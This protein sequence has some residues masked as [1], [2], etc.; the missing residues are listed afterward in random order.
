MRMFQSSGLH[1]GEPGRIG[2]RGAQL[3]RTC[4]GGG[5]YDGI[6]AQAHVV[7]GPRKNVKFFSRTRDEITASFPE[8]PDS[9][10]G[11]A[12]D[13]ILDGEILA[14]SYGEGRKRGAG[15]S[16]QQRCSSGSDGKKVS[17]ELMRRVPVV[18]IVC[19]C[20]VRGRRTA[21]RAAA[22]G[23]NGHSGCCLAAPRIQHGEPET[24]RKPEKHRASLHFEGLSEMGTGCPCE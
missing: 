23:T 6:R 21:A 11:I 7:G 22:P 14:W 17:A 20:L 24:R 15:D 10:A 18:Y 2:R 13:A 19:R 3:L 1:A 5:Q 9:L 16:F 12:K 8:L 4:V